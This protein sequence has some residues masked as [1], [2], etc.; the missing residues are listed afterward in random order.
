VGPSRPRLALVE[1]FRSALAAR[2]SFAGLYPASAAGGEGSQAL[3]GRVLDPAL[4]VPVTK[5]AVGGLCCPRSE[6]AEVSVL[7]TRS[8]ISCL[9]VAD[10]EQVGVVVGDS[11]SLRQ[12]RRG[13]RVDYRGGD[14]RACRL[15]LAH[16]RG[17]LAAPELIFDE[18]AVIM[19]GTWPNLLDHLL[20]AVET[21]SR[22]CGVRSSCPVTARPILGVPRMTTTEARTAAAATDQDLP[23]VPARRR[24]IGVDREQ[25]C[26]GGERQEVGDV[27]V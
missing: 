1:Q 13:I 18:N 12:R 19:M 5:Q 14:V 20:V 25:Q 11:G 2:K 24:L 21:V 7:S 17:D 4:A 10:L 15:V 16:G 23:V 26:T 9:L 6:I 22:F 27:G 3:V 8:S